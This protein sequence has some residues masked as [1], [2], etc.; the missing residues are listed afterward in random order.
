M[1]YILLGN[2]F[3]ET[4]AIA[5]LDCLRRAGINVTTVGIDAG[6]ITSA[7]GLV[8]MP[9]RSLESLTEAELAETEL[10]MLPGGLGGVAAITGSEAAMSLI[11]YCAE[12]DR[13]IAAICA[14]PTI[15]GGL[16]LLDGRPATVYPGMESGLGAALPQ[17]APVV[18]SGKIITGEAAGSAWEFGFALVSALRGETAARTV[19]DAIHFHH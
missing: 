15:L 13:W 16:G 1:V 4:E 12:Q 14:A 6:A 7:H 19:A 3:E 17:Y 8:V 11:R 9:D 10:V 5:P 2:G 18:V